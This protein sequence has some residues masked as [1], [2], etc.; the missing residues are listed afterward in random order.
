MGKANKI[1]ENPESQNREAEPGEL[2]CKLA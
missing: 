2:W 1:K